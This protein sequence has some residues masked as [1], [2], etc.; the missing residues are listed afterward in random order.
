MRRRAFITLLG[1]VAAGWP[2]AARAQQPMPV[3]G[4]LHN[5]SAGAWAPFITAFRN[6]L[7]EVGYV[8]GQNVT[9]EYRWAEGRDDRVPELAAEL[10]RRP[11][12]VIVTNTIGAQA[13][14]AATKT[15]PIIFL[16]GTDPVKLGLVAS[17][18]RPGGNM[19]GVNF[20]NQ[21]LEA[22]RLGLLHELVPKA[23]LVAV[24]VNPNRPDATDQLGKVKEAVLGLGLRTQIL[25]ANTVSEIESGFAS[26]ARQRAD[27]L[28]VTA[29]PFL[30]SR[31]DQIVAL[32]ARHAIPTIYSTHEFTDAGGL[33][34]YGTSQTDGYRQAG[35]YA[36]RV[37]KG[38]KPA[39]LPV[40]QSTKFE[41][42]INLKT[43][44]LL[45]LEVP[46]SL[47]ASADGVIE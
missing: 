5:A 17:L 46:P 21:E 29:D 16:V 38:E 7:N 40:M 35:V 33:M 12:S 10:I 20:F 42:L 32:A 9:I 19:T 24:L 45:G 22:K 36:G 43:A 1:G 23:A 30:L 8:D 25:N 47:S 18:N 2:L 27:A 37:L 41:F 14:G 28:I 39:D 26:F 11:V 4:F 13:A 31:R 34:S 44:K 6:G 3:V 15:I